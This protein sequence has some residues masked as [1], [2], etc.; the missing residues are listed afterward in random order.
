[1]KRRLRPCCGIWNGGLNR[2]VKLGISQDWRFDSR[3]ALL[4]GRP[5]GYTF[6]PVKT[7]NS[8]C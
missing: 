2:Q 1:M 8:R 3:L 5:A 6:A 4:A 7:P